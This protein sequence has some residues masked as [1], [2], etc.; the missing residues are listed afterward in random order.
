[1]S[2]MSFSNNFNNRIYRSDLPVPFKDIK[3]YISN[4][5]VLFMVKM[6]DSTF[7]VVEFVIYQKVPLNLIG[8]FDGRNCLV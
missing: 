5:Q 7:L 1:M 3:F 8:K 2:F 4:L 6:F